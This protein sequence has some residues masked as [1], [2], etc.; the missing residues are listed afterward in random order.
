MNITE[1]FDFAGRTVLVTGGG[2]GIGRAAAVLFAT[3][4]A[5]VT[6]A[7]RKAKNLEAVAEEV[8]ALGRR[9]LVVPVDLL[10]EDGADAMVDA[11][12]RHYGGCDV[13]VNNSGGSYMFPLDSWD[14]A[15]WH[16]MI[17]LNLRSVWLASRRVEPAMAAVGHGVILNVSSTASANPIPEV[18]PYS[19]AKAGVEHLTGVLAAA[20]GG[21]GVRVN[22][23]RVG[24]VKSEGYLRSMSRSGR[25]PDEAGGRNA[26]HR[27]GWP[28]EVAHA[29]VFLASA[30]ASFITG[31]TLAVD[32]G[33]QPLF[34]AV[35]S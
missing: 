21:H 3:Q 34:D 17:D 7:S 15:N 14:L 11:H 1:S 8:T 33:A 16:R 23:V 2:T 32:G 4:G 35:P 26:L 10:D 5:D 19:V 24:P 30:G 18:A 13:L 31:A 27:A 12:L 28:F 9:A 22:C 20:W 25:D 29:L 6:L